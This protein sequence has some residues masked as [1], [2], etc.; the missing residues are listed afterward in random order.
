MKHRLKRL[1]LLVQADLK[2][3]F[4]SPWFYMVLGMCVAIVYAFILIQPRDD[5][6]RVRVIDE[7]DSEASREIVGRLSEEDYMIERVVP[8]ELT[9]RQAYDES[10]EL[11]KRDRVFAVIWIAK[12]HV[13]RYRVYSYLAEDN[14]RYT[15]ERVLERYRFEFYQRLLLRSGGA[16]PELETLPRPFLSTVGGG[17]DQVAVII[18]SGI[19]YLAGI[20]TLVLWILSKDGFAKLMRIYSFPEILIARTIAGSLLGILLAITFFTTAHVLG[21]RFQ[22]FAGLMGSGFLSVLTGVLTGLLLGAFALSLGGSIF[23]LMLIGLLGLTLLFLLLT[24]ISGMF[25]PLGGLPV[26]ITWLGRGLPMFGQIELLRWSA[27]GGYSLL[28]PLCLRLIGNL[29]II[30]AVQFLLSL[31]FLRRL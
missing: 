10:S 31:A 19:W 23:S 6:S 13:V 9:A 1:G 17:H 18:V 5:L 16:W 27:L 20:T 28:D 21:I 26:W 29:L 14:V 22:S 3:L 25:V 15:L 30:D 4:Y 2:L 24:I 7:L 8:G 11:M 12:D